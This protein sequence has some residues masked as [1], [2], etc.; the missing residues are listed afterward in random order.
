MPSNGVG[1][2]T[3]Q[4]GGAVRKLENGAIPTYALSILIG[5]VLLIAYFLFNIWSRR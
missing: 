4:L 5:A 1:R 3:G 2:V